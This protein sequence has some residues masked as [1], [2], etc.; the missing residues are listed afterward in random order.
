MTAENPIIQEHPHYQSR[1]AELEQYQDLYRGGE[2]FKKNAALYLTRRQREPQDVYNER[3]DRVFYENYAGSIID[4]FGT[5]LFRREPQI[6][7]IGGSES[8]RAFLSTFVDDCDQRGTNL[9]EFFRRQVT[10]AMTFGASFTLLDFPRQGEALSRAD[11]DELGYSRAYLKSYSPLEVISWNRD[12]AGELEWAVVREDGVRKTDAGAAGWVTETRW[13]YYGREEFRVFR[14]LDE[15]GKPGP[16]EETAS[17]AHGLAKLHR[18]PLFE[19]KLSDGLWLMRK[20]APIQVEHFNKSNALSWALTMGLFAMPVVYSDREFRQII[21]ESYYIQLGPEDKFGWTEPEGHVY[22]LAMQNLSR[23]ERELYRICYLQ[24]QAA[25]PL[26]N[27]QSQSGLSKQRDFAITQ[28]VL[29]GL[30]DATKDVIKAVLAAIE[31]VRE[32][33]MTV[34]VAGLD[35]FDVGDFSDELSDAERLLTLG[36]QSPT[37]TEQVHKRLALKYLADAR[38]GIKDQIAREIEQTGARQ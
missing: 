25:S 7:T 34:N 23:L 19:L 22:Q 18:V 9:S 35:E 33:G 24:N 36:I 30:G 28:E 6:L 16:V 10:Q 17:G 37:L 13:T 15:D 14:R 32:D 1:R 26:E 21:G 3:L 27:G 31:R 8:S 12:E 2:E 5:T 4:W 20:A 11:E 38:Q 29:R